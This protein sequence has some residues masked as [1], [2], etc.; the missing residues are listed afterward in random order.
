MS[1]LTNPQ[2]PDTSKVDDDSLPPE[3][4]R[5]V[6][7]L[8]LFLHLFA[9]FIA[10]ASNARPVSALRAQLGTVPGVKP[11]LQTLMMDL[12]YTYHLTYAQGLDFDHFFEVELDW[13][14]TTN[15]QAKTLVLPQPNT[16]PNIRFRRYRD[17]VQAAA[18]LI[19]EEVDESR[20]PHVIAS[21][22]L[23][24][25]GVEEGV[26]RIR[27]RRRL[28]LRMEEAGSPDLAER[29]PSRPALFETIYEA[30]LKFYRGELILTKAAGALETAPLKKE[31]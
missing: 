13:Q 3:G 14:G 26:H 22:L 10:V 19:S 4:I 20:L 23:S 7:S 8:V 6:L 12:S 11:Y 27:C 9:L 5:T 15:P 30:D 1:E 29:D 28:P 24:E 31:E 25:A 21:R 18:V 17:L 2:P 16:R